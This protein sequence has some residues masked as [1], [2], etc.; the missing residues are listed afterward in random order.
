MH[1][2]DPTPHYLLA[3]QATIQVNFEP[4]G[5]P[6]VISLAELLHHDHCFRIR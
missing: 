3:D 2:I 5:E 1:I 6:Q 4:L